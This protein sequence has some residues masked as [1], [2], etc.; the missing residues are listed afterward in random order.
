MTQDPASA[1][2]LAGGR[3]S[4]MG[5][6]KAALRFG[7]AT[8]IERLIAE[9]YPAFDELIVVAAPSATETFAADELLRVWLPRIRLLRDADTF[10]GPVPALI[11]GL[12]AA[13]NPLAFVCSCDL[14]LIRAK[15]ARALCTMTGDFDVVVPAIAGK[16]QPLC[17][18]YRQ[19]AADKIEDLARRGNSRLTAIVDQLDCRRI[20]EAELQRIDP[21]LRSFLNVNTPADYARALAAAGFEP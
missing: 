18:A 9:L 8:I 13:R 20:A 12:R 17:A 15:V 6:P 4:R 21:D 7:P 2:I 11:H 3:S 19:T 14:P 10:A 16:S 1:I 5:Q